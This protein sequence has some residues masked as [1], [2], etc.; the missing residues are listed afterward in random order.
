M[1]SISTP[2][3][4]QLQPVGG[5]AEDSVPAI[6]SLDTVFTSASPSPVLQE[7][8]LRNRS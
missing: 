7:L 4:E 1:P 2:E 6:L 5:Q 3:H 8:E